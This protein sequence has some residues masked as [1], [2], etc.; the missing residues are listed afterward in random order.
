MKVVVPE[1]V[2]DIINKYKLNSK[3]RETITVSQRELLNDFYLM[4]AT[5]ALI[6]NMLQVTLDSL[7]E[8]EIDRIYDKI[9]DWDKLEKMGLSVLLQDSEE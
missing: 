2:H 9:T 5:T 1:V 7:P 8:Y 6:A 4:S 3:D